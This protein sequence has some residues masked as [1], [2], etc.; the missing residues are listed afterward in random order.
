MAAVFPLA[1]V[2]VNAQFK[3]IKAAPFSTAVA[4]QKIRTLLEN[5][6]AGNRDR[7]VATISDWLNWYRDVLDE[8]LIARWKS[9][10]RANI[11]LV[12]APLADARVAREIIEFSWHGDRAAAFTPAAAPMLED[13]MAR[14]PESAKP[15]L[16]DLLSSALPPSPSQAD[17]ETV[18]RI[19]LD[20]PDIG[21]WRRSALRI[22]PRYRAAADRLLKQD[23]ASP[24]QERV[25]RA[26][27]WRT[28]LGL[29]PPAVSRQKLLTRDTS[30]RDTPQLIAPSAVR[31]GNAQRGY[32][33]PLSGIFVST[34]DPIP[35]NGEYVFPNIPPIKLLLDFDTKHWE[36]RLAPGEGQTQVLVL[37]NKG[38]GAQKHC[39]VRW[40]VVP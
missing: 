8:E 11:P 19:L 12:V 32:T 24:D 27:R 20:M 39:V 14:Y 18:C 28:D 38:R 16:D 2:P 23:L 25:Y 10:G 26:L 34:G 6:D 33:G 1:N 31:A 30:P 29:D 4:R 15:F 21:T 13:L 22:L 5:V 36:A 9:E 40:S 7:T 37:R 17:A 35:E 3:E